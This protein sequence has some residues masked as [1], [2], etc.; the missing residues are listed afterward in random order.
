VAVRYICVPIVLYMY[1]V[2]VSAYYY[3]SI[4][5]ASAA[6]SCASL[7]SKG[8]WRLCIVFVSS[9]YYICIL[10]HVCPHTTIYASSYYSICVLIRQYMCP[11][12]MIYVSSY[13]L[14]VIHVCPQASPGGGARKTTPTPAYPTTAPP[15]RRARLSARFS[16]TTPS[17]RWW[18]WM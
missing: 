14:C 3:N 13:Y 15:T 9:Y 1:T 6:G 4:Y 2:Y 12:T 7:L 5:S 8:F 16:R 17:R 11:H 10:M 18:I